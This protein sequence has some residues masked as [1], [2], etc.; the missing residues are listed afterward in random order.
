MK[1]Q[2][3]NNVIIK[4]LPQKLTNKTQEQHQKYTDIIRSIELGASMSKRQ[5]MS[6]TF[7]TLNTQVYTSNDQLT[8]QIQ[9]Q[10]FKQKIYRL[11]NT[12]HQFV[13][14][15]NIMEQATISNEEKMQKLQKNN[16]KLKIYFQKSA[17]V[18]DQNQNSDNFYNQYPKKIM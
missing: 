1:Y 16:Q 13:R 9:I 8:D 17:I 14:M 11:I 10:Q 3:E 18:Y 2:R 5:S 4:K 6:E 15:I 7:Q 12:S